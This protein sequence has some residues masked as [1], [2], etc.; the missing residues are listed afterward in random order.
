MDD[1]QAIREDARI[2]VVFGDI[3]DA[4]EN[5]AVLFEAPA[6]LWGGASASFSPEATHPAGCTCCTTRGPAGRAL[7]DLL[8][9]RARGK[10]PFFKRVIA[11]TRT[12]AG[13]AEI[14]AALAQDPIATA[15]FR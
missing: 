4:A 7:G 9:A 2:P 6:R 1:P 11:V 14:L 5:D 12:D 8:H 10:T 3:A 13:R 15:C